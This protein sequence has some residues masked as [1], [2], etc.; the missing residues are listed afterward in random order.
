MPYIDSTNINKEMNRRL[1][2]TPL[3]TRK[4][5]N[6]GD[7]RWYITLKGEDYLKKEE[8]NEI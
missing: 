6:Q 7:Y 5:I 4:K 8:K 1:L 2:K 3:I